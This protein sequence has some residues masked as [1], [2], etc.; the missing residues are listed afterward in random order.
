MDEC[1]LGLMPILRY[2][3]APKGERPVVDIHPR[4]KWFYVF[5]AIEPI[6]GDN[7]SLICDAVCLEMMQY[8]L[9]EFSKTLKDNELC[10]LVLDGAGWHNE[11]GLKIPDNIV[12]LPQP[13]YSPE[14][15]PAERLWTWTRERLANKVFKNLDELVNATIDIINDWDKFKSILKSWVCY[16]WWKDALN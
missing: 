15:N 11:K 5:S 12:L 3:W 8:W 7:F 16:S 1:R 14:C 13:P 2:I 9:N 6:T 4:Y 10:L